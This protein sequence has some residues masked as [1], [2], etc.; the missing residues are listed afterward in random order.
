MCA[1]VQATLKS[2]SV[3]V[4]FNSEADC[5]WAFKQLTGDEYTDNL[6]RPEKRNAGSLGVTVRMSCSEGGRQFASSKVSVAKSATAT[7]KDTKRATKSS[8][9]VQKPTVTKA[10]ESDDEDEEDAATLVAVDNES[11]E[12]EEDDED[13]DAADDDDDDESDDDSENLGV[14]V[15]AATEEALHTD[16]EAEDEDDEDL[17]VDEDSGSDSGSDDD[18]EGSNSDAGD[19]QTTQAR[20]ASQKNTTTKRKAPAPSSGG[21][22]YAGAHTKLT[23]AMIATMKVAELKRACA[24]RELKKTGNKEELRQRL[25]AQMLLELRGKKAATEST[26][27]TAEEPSRAAKKPRLSGGT[28]T[29]AVLDMGE[30]VAFAKRQRPAWLAW[31]TKHAQKGKTAAKDPARHTEDDLRSFWQSLQ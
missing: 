20:T 19:E 5:N 24:D 3:T 9:K 22:S 1:C 12:D 10:Q 27:A 25:A 15:K 6:G 28:S 31:L 13:E 21:T 4:C 18:D 7:K 8:V 29:E 11:D 2:K 16:S 23:A 14:A 17:S 26:G 30:L